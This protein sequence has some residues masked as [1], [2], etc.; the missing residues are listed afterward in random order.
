MWEEECLGSGKEEQ[1]NLFFPGCGHQ[2]PLLT[3]CSS[4]ATGTSRGNKAGPLPY[5]WAGAGLFPVS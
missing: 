3:E 1:V 2:T 4:K 5:L